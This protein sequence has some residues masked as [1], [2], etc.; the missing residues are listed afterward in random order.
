MCHSNVCSRQCSESNAGYGRNY[1]VESSR[2]RR[3][4]P[5]SLGQELSLAPIIWLLSLALLFTG[6]GWLFR[7]SS[8]R[9]PKT[10]CREA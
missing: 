10:Q 2:S 9:V 4:E 5:W 6:G 8:G 1:F 7:S 3:I